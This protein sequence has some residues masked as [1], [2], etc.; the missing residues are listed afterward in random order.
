MPPK[1]QV[2]TLDTIALLESVDVRIAE[3]GGV[4]VVVVP[5]GTDAHAM[6]SAME[7]V[8]NG[9]AEQLAR[10]LPHMPDEQSANLVATGSM[11]QRTTGIERVMDPE[12]S[13]PACQ[14]AGNSPMWMLESLLDLGDSRRIVVLRG[15]V[16]YEWID[17][18]A[19]PTRAGGAVH[20]SWTVWAVVGHRGCPHPSEAW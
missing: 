17:A 18:A 9:G 20:G 12:L 19:P 14:K 10:M 6:E 2:P 4:K 8:K 15:R 13:L 16:P 5:I 7:V 11:V 1:G 3:R